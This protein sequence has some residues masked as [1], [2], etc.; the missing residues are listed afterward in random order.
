MKWVYTSKS[1]QIFLI[2]FIPFFLGVF[3]DL[4]SKMFSI[5]INETIMN[6]IGYVSFI[7]LFGWLLSLGNLLNKKLPSNV[8]YSNIFFNVSLTIVILYI[9]L[10][11]IRSSN[12]F[13][14][15]LLAPYIYRSF[16]INMI[17]M[18]FMFYAIHFIAKNLVMNERKDK[19]PFG[20]HIQ[21][22]FMLWFF[23]I[24][25]WYLQPRIMR[26]FNE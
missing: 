20:A 23:P 13:L 24:G 11:D 2:L 26:I 5:V 6:T 10:L 18:F 17:A 19:I 15:S 12:E 1:W 9:I 25:I 14:N 3:L 7:I 4:I 22:F 21:E 16:T 8:K